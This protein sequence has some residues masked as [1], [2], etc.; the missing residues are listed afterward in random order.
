MATTP[1]QPGYGVAWH[2]RRT[3]SGQSTRT[4]AGSYGFHLVR[5]GDWRIG[6]FRFNLKF[7]EGNTRLEQ[8]D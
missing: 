1:M 8:S 5:H 2:Y 3:R 6:R 7:I 4:L